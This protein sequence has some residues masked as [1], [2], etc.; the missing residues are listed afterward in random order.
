MLKAGLFT[1]T[2]GAV[3]SDREEACRDLLG[4]ASWTTGPGV[5]ETPEGWVA[6]EYEGT[7]VTC[8]E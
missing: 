4:P 1:S 7:V 2:T 8:C 6:A 3:A 5:G